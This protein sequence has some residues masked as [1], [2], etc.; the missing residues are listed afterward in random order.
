[1]LIAKPAAPD[2]LPWQPPHAAGGGSAGLWNVASLQP[3]RTCRADAHKS[4]STSLCRHLWLALERPDWSP[5]QH[6]RFPPRFRR[7]VQTLLLAAHGGRGAESSD[8][9]AGDGDDSSSSSALPQHLP[10]LPPDLLL[11]IV[12]HAAY[13]LSEWAPGMQE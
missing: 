13:P 5:V 3:G 8:G 1:M 6:R 12:G 2:G 4:L 10:A 7:A 11:R 9:S